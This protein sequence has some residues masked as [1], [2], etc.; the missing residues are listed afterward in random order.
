MIKVS[1]DRTPMICGNTGKKFSM[2]SLSVYSDKA[3]YLTVEYDPR[4]KS[5]EIAVGNH[6][7]DIN[8]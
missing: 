3:D 7:F 1:L 6:C 5:A 2:V 8:R 4:W